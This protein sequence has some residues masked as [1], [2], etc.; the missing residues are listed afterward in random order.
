MCEFYMT[1]YSCGCLFVRYS[2]FL[3]CEKR[4]HGC[5]KT[6]KR[7]EWKTRCPEIRKALGKSPTR[8][9]NRLPPCA[10]TLTIDELNGL[11]TKCDS[12]NTKPGAFKD[13]QCNK[14]ECR[15]CTQ[16]PGLLPPDE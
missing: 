5:A 15:V 1:Y 4:Q 12:L 10:K 14:R 7:Y 2:G 8:A 3:L 11:C 16:K 9:G 13:W 6:M